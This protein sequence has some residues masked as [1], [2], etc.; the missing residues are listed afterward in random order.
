MFMIDTHAHFNTIVLKDLAQQ[1]KRVELLSYLDKVINVGLDYHT[2][3]EAI[4]ISLSHEK[5][6]AT[7]GIHPL[8]EGTVETLEKLY[9]QY[10]CS[11]VIAIGETGL[12][13]SEKQDSAIQ[14]EK[15]I[16]TIRF[17]NE[18]ALPIII[19]ANNT[20]KR[21]LDILKENYPENGFVF[22]CFQPNLEIMEEIIRM[23]GYISVATPITRPTAK[24]SLE[25]IKNVPLDCLL[26]EL[27]YPYM[28][29]N[30]EEDGKNIFNKIRELRKISYYE[31][32]DVLD[33]NARRLFRLN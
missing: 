10:D 25:V 5:F 8:W 24:R 33:S 15:F 21:V 3:K 20:N 2:S 14:E 28:S 12:D 18:V 11:K 6:Y 4:S 9:A 27:D 19:H 7:L 22:H 1:I 30:V 16:K 13:S 17:A 23:S 32:E 26:I 29:E 31:L